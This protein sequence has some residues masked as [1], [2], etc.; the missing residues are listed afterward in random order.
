MRIS[1]DKNSQKKILS[2]GL[3]DTNSK[4]EVYFASL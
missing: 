3:T 4:N 1:F 2:V